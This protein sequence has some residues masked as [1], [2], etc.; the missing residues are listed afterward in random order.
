MQLNHKYRPSSKPSVSRSMMPR[1][2]SLVVMR[3]KSDETHNPRLL[4]PNVALFSDEDEA[5]MVDEAMSH[6]ATE[7]SEREIE[8]ISHGIVS[9]I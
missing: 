7:Q 2:K 1:A 3:Y 8:R 9:L 4:P 5:K 6:L